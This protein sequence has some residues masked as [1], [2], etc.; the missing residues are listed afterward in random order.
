MPNSDSTIHLCE[1]C[2][3]QMRSKAQ[4]CAFCNTAG[5]R[6]MAQEENKQIREDL[7]RRYPRKA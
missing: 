6:A 2:G 4:Y 7:D 5:K 1:N 3:G